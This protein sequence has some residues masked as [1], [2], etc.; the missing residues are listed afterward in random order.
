M[1]KNKEKKN[2]YPY[3]RWRLSG[4]VDGHLIYSAIFTHKIFL[5][6]LLNILSTDRDLAEAWE[7]SGILSTC[8][9]F[10]IPQKEGTHQHQLWISHFQVGMWLP[11]GIWLRFYFLIIEIQILDAWKSE[12]LCKCVGR[13]E[14]LSFKKHLNSCFI[15]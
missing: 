3:L 1:L 7:F 12:N 5:I 6:E 13:K 9:W 4:T 15:F 14:S 10:N 11:L 2:S 8:A